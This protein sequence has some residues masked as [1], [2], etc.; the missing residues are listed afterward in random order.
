M[1]LRSWN[2]KSSSFASQTARSNAFRMPR[3]ANADPALAARA[4][5]Q[6]RVHGVVHRHLAAPAR[7]GPLTE[8]HAAREVDAVPGESLDLA[9]PHPGAERHRDHPGE[10]GVP[11]LAARGEH[12]RDLLLGQE[13]Q[14]ALALA[15]LLNPQRALLAL[16]KSFRM[17]A[18]IPALPLRRPN[19]VGAPRAE[20]GLLGHP[21]APGGADRRR[22]DH[23]PVTSIMNMT[24]SS[25]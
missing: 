5:G 22:N 16:G 15:L 14:P 23:S 1:Y 24:R 11:G 7:L 18:P 8:Q 9:P 13:P 10:L 25:L 6:D 21:I 20:A 2:R 3:V 4:R 17:P 12:A 19:G